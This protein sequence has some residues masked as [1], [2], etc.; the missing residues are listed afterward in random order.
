M[1]IEPGNINK[2]QLAP[3]VQA[4][5]SNYQ[6]AHKGARTKLLEY[7]ENNDENIIFDVKQSEQ[8][9]RYIQKYNRNIMVELQDD[10]D[11]DDNFIWIN[12]ETVR[13]LL[14]IDNLINSCARSVLSI[15]LLKSAENKKILFNKNKIFSLIDEKNKSYTRSKELKFFSLMNLNDWFIDTNGTLKSKDK[16]Q[17]SILG[18]RVSIPG[19]ENSNWSQPILEENFLGEYK[20]L[21][22]SKL[23]TSFYL[24]RKTE[25]PGIR[26]CVLAP[27]QILRSSETLGTLIDNEFTKKT[28][29]IISVELSEEGGRFF[30]SS[31]KHSVYEVSQLEAHIIKKE[32]LIPLSLAEIAYLI[33]KY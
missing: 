33:K 32:N 31:F 6:R 9:F 19:R 17:F 4:T 5:S 20:L 28:R 8:G 3:T 12:Q 21:R 26:G 13:N 29:K 11:F 18:I 1:K 24:F 22:Y 15:E 2:I 23:N 7:F 14:T 10:I 25:E 16:N 30:Q 27:T